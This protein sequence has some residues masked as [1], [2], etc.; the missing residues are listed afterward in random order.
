MMLQL[1]IGFCASSQP[2]TLE[3]EHT[4]EELSAMIKDAIAGQMLEVTD[5]QGNVYIMPS[6][7]IAY[8]SIRT[9]SRHSVGFG[10]LA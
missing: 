8:T 9:A 4:A 7:S 1:E 6:A 2:I 5:R 3:V 10:A